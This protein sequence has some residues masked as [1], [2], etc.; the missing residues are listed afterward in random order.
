VTLANPLTYAA[1]GLPF[2]MVPAVAGHAP[3]TLTLGWVLLVLCGSPA[4]VLGVALRL[5][6]RRVL[7]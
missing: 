7:T 4:V 2:A 6:R 1:E 3:Q 5:F